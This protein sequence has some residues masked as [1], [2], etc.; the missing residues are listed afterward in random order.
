[1]SHELLLADEQQKQTRDLVTHAAWGDR[2]TVAQYR[3]RE[4][5]LRAHPWARS[6]ME[7]WLWCDGPTV[8]ASC[9]S[10]R[11][12]SLLR[13]SSGATHGHTF[14]IASVY[15]EPA[16]RGRG[17]AGA[18]MS[19][20]VTRFRSDPLAQASLLFS[21][22][23]PELYARSGYVERPAAEWQLEA[24][25]GDP[26]E[27]VDLLFAESAVAAELSHTQP[28][29]DAFVVW[30]TVSQLDWHFER[31]RIYASLL[32]RPRLTAWGARV[33]HSRLF[34][35]GDLKNDRVVVLLHELK[36]I[37]DAN[38]LLRCARRVAAAAGLKKVVIWERP[39]SFDWN[40][41][42]DGHRV[43]RHE[44]TIPMLCPL[45]PDLNPNSWFGLGRSLWI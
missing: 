24:S 21:D 35:V 28:P 30:P 18:L 32:A 44:D 3:A 16:F 40:G 29:P 25:G 27:T 1:V 19:A 26:G 11:M 14:G 36:S 41:L 7:T 6:G 12:P 31:E 34:W 42:T 15:T 13:T 33:G 20:L 45:N 4:D 22:V 43:E 5:R 17:H 37:D 10:F 38:R 39:E 8:L 2:L 9:E 23:R